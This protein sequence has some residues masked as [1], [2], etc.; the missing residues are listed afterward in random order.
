MKRLLVVDDDEGTRESLRL[1][2]S[3]DY[4]LKLTA[5][6]REA[7]GV[8]A[9][10]SVDLILLD[11]LM[12]EKDGVTLLK[13]LTALYPETP[14]IM[15][16][17]STNARPIVESMKSGTVDFVTKPF[18]VK[19]LRHLVKRSLE[20][21]TLRQRVK[22]M[23]SDVKRV[24]P[25]EGMIGDSA[26][27][28]AALQNAKRAAQTDATVLIHGESGTGKEMVARHI[29]RWSDRASEP[30]VAVH[31]AAIPEALMESE[32]FGH[33]KG[34]FTNAT[35]QKL[36]RF[37]LAGSGTLFFDEVGE[38]SLNTQ[39]KLLRVLQER[40]YMRLGGNR[41]LHTNARIL[42]AT[43]R[44][45]LEQVRIGA[46]REDLYYRLNVVPI[47]IPP[48]RE[49][50]QDVVRLCFHYL[51]QF[52]ANLNADVTE[53]EPDALE[54]LQAYPW[55]GNIRELRNVIERSVVLHGHHPSLPRHLL[56]HEFQDPAQIPTLSTQALTENL[57]QSVEQVERE[58]LIEA[59]RAC[60]GVQTR[61][62]KMLGTT[63]RILKYKMDKHHIS[64]PLEEEENL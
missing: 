12:P 9:A 45:L 56:P 61:A 58:L 64:L 31:C 4:S 2:F 63:R 20:H 51:E 29:H 23:E 13:E 15:I 47:E 40:E 62:A 59:L 17:A 57:S 16:S 1:I 25:E 36:G 54:A 34:A 44:N 10:Q 8:L 37:D 27:F 7:L 41:V 30:F 49:R 6:S 33:E 3:Q 46:F 38:M 48:L 18:D 28:Q 22:A 32:L 14:V 5:T 24:F 11:V 35:S 43:N 55:P 42:A 21:Q 39:V 26:S 53:I 19:E 50:H 60:D 52:R